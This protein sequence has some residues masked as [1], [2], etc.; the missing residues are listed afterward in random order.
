MSDRK[1]FESWAATHDMDLTPTPIACYSGIYSDCN[2]DY[3]WL[4]WQSATLAE[5]ER[6]AKVCEDIADLVDYPAF[7]NECADAIRQEPA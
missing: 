4:A 6:C 7:A 2:T 5:R 3:A 1:Q